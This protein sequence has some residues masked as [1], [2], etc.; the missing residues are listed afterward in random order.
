MS[1]ELEFVFSF[2]SPYAWIA[3][4]RVLPLVH[5]ET[6]IR[7]TPFLPRPSFRNFG[8]VVPG[9]VR[10]ILQ[11]VLRL[12]EAYQLPL[13]RPPIDDSDWHLAHAAF[14][15][16]DRAGHGPAFAR[17]LFDER[18]VKSQLVSTDAA[19]GRVA[20][21]VGLD[22]NA[23]IAAANDAELRAELTALVE[24]NY[25]E[26]SVFGVPMFILPSGEQFW[27]HDRMEWAIRRGTV[28]AAA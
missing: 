13:G 3:L 9:K 22:G 5:P 15:W 28:R 23:A 20:A 16:A 14:L 4:R 19:I 1:E 24:T 25:E 18:W 2:R 12:S 10:H 27:G 21:A 8:A 17:A 11:D 6:R 7:W 26:R